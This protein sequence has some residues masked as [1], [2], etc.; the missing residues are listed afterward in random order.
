MIVNLYYLKQ[1]EDSEECGSPI[2]LA[3]VIACIIKSRTEAHLK[4]TRTA[5]S[6]KPIVISVEY[7]QC[8]N[9]TLID[10]LVLSL[11]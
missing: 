1:D 3:S 5:V 7:A 8:P 10:T 6:S 11:R 9:L 4:K 2:V